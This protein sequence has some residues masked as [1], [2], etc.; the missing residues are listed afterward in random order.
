[1][2]IKPQ[3]VGVNPIRKEDRM[4]LIKVINGD[5]WKIDLTAYNPSDYSPA[6]PENTDVVFSIAE[7]RFSTEMFW[8][9]TWENGITEDDNRPGLVHINVPNEISGSLRR[10][11]YSFS[12]SV[13]DKNGTV[14]KTETIGNIQ[15]EYE[16]NSDTHSIPY[17]DGSYSSGSTPS[18]STYTKEEID[19]KLEKKAD[20]DSISTVGFS[21]DYEDL[22]NKKTDL[23]Q[24]ENSSDD[25]YA[26]TS[27]VDD[28]VENLRIHEKEIT[29]GIQNQVD[30]KV[31]KVE[32]V[33]FDVSTESA[34]A[35]MCITASRL[36][37]FRI[38]G[39]SDD[40]QT[41]S[42]ISAKFGIPPTDATTFSDLEI[43]AGLSDTNTPADLI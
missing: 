23:S 17:R 33:S 14:K 4:P 28:S 1:M 42:T 15:V 29:D 43:S 13:S 6:T 24:F 18:S 20:I 21:G 10:G 26:K 30:A 3:P 22:L 39:V 31:D 40:I 9:G 34:F 12:F 37:G 19:E 36:L 41:P 5:S 7:N 11:V 27:T 16:N 35:Q 32:G 2:Y 25:P 8:V 38:T